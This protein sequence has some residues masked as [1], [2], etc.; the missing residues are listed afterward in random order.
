MGGGMNEFGAEGRGPAWNYNLRA[1]R[2]WVTFKAIRLDEI[3][4]GRKKV[5]GSGTEPGS[6]QLLSVLGKMLRENARQGGGG[7]GGGSEGR[8]PGSLVSPNPH[9]RKKR[10]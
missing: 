1:T 4:V 7:R 5:K 8:D 2:L 9:V 6:P 3:R 10:E